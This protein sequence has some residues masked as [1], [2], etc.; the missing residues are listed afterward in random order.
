MLAFAEQMQIHFA[1]DRPVLIWIA[2]HRLGAVPTRQAQVIIEIARRVRHLGLKKSVA[3]NFLRFNCRLSVPDDVD[4]VCVRTKCANG[5]I[6]SHPMRSQN[7]E[8]IG[9]CAG[10][11]AVQLIRR[12]TGHGERFHD[13]ST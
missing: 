1:H 5:E 3:M 4:L 10:E 9:M 2:H 12:Q 13:Y 11:K 8:R 7:S 6:V